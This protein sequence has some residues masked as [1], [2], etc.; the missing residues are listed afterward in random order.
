[1]TIDELRQEVELREREN[2]EFMI[3][4][5]DRKNEPTG[6]R[7]RVVPGVLGELVAW[8]PGCAVV[9]VKVADLRRFLEKAAK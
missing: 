1:M 6:H 2:R 9:S 3:V 8:N 7:V 5:V 4:T